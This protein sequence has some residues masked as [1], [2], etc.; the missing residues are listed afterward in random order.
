[1][2]EAKERKDPLRH[3]KRPGH[4]IAKHVKRVLS[5]SATPAQNQSG[6][7]KSKKHRQGT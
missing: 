2:V 5:P 6:A 3:V 7:V 4:Y 1:M